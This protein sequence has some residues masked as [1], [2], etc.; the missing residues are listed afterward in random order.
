[1]CGFAGEFVFGDGRADVDLA[2]RMAARLAHRGPDEA[3]SYLSSDGRCAIGF[4]RLAVIDPAGSHQPMTSADRAVTVAFNGEIYNFRDLRRELAASGADFRTQ[5]D[6]EVLLHLYSRHGEDLLPRLDGMFA[7]AIHDARE[8]S[9]L[10]ARDRLG[11]KPLWYA[12]LPDRVIFASE[13]KAL[14]EHPAVDPALDQQSLAYYQTSGYIPAPRTAWLGVRK[15][16][17]GCMLQLDTRSNAPR[18]Y[19]RLPIEPARMSRRDARQAVRD[20]LAASVAARMVSDVP[21]GALLSGGLDSA[22]IVALMAQVAGGAGGV[23]TFTAG[24]EHA[25]YDERNDARRLAAHC[26]TDH[27]ELLVR[28]AP[29][30]TLDTLVQMYDEPFADSSALAT[31]LICRAAREHVTVALVGDGGDEAFAGYDRYRAVHL[32]SSLGP[33]AYTAVRLAALPARLFAPHQ[34]RSRLRRLVRFADG[35]ALPPSQQYLKYRSLFEYTDLPRLFRPEWASEV[36]LAGPAEWFWEL[37]EQEDVPDEVARCQRHDLL[38]YLPD[39]LLVK[40][41]IAS[42]AASLELRT[43]ML[44]HRLVSLGLSL[45]AGMKIAHGRGKAILR[46]AFADMLPPETLRGRKRGFGI[47][48]SDW[49]R[50]ELR[51]VLV[52]TLMDASFLRRGIFEPT[53]VGG[54]INDHLRG[55]DDHG[56]RLWSLLVLARWLDKHDR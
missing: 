38:T 45:P 6:T 34:E 1:M 30:E 53:A 54:L 43:P 11:E 13:A 12:E 8:A 14:L 7:L 21:L 49:L 17:P 9:L 22:I 37:Y 52:G 39:D 28:P 40:S 42:M 20:A 27:T 51:D 29:A 44:D 33:A 56:H 36:D 48:I 32:S 23:R 3:S 15:L 24:F 2:Q 10:L 16:L 19:W 50:G 46:E 41:D 35:M 5:G 47:P 26:G 4:C 25:S 31:W 55:R 18:P